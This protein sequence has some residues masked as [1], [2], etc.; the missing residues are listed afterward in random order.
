MLEAEFMFRRDK[1]HT[2][3]S[4]IDHS[5]EE[6]IIEEGNDYYDDGYYDYAD[7]D[8]STQGIIAI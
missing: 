2:L 7:G 5:H 3:S 8:P 4:F 1:T 6:N